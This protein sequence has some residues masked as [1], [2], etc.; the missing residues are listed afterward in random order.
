MKE[1]I[2]SSFTEE[3]MGENINLIFPTNIRI[4]PGAETFSLYNDGL[5]ECTYLLDESQYKNSTSASIT[6]QLGEP[7]YRLDELILILSLKLMI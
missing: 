1:V 5:G 2:K 6:L 3:K 7:P 4:G